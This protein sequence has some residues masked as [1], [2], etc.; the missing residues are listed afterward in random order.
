LPVVIEFGKWIR[1]R[2]MSVAVDV[3]VARALS[4]GRAGVGVG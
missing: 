1:R 2:R 4:P 3:G